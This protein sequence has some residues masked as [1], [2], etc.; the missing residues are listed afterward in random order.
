MEIVRGRIIEG[1]N[2]N[3]MPAAAG[4]K[5]KNSSYTFSYGYSFNLS[6]KREIRSLIPSLTF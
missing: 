6:S 1:A 2:L 4:L 3:L 5:G